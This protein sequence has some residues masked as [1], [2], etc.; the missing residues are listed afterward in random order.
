[1]KILRLLSLLLTAILISLN[2]YADEVS[3]GNNPVDV[4]NQTTIIGSSVQSKDNND[5]DNKVS[6]IK[7]LK[8]GKIDMNN[9]DPRVPRFVRFCMKVYKW[10]DRTFNSTDTNYVVGTGRR[11]KARM[12]SDN[13]VETYNLDLEKKLPVELNSDIYSN[14]GAYLQYMALSLG[15][16]F[17]LSNIIG[18]RRS[19]HRKTELGFNCARFNVE[20]HYWENNGG[21][22]IRRFGEYQN[23]EKVDIPFNGLKLRTFGVVGYYFFNNR[24]YSM[25]AAYNFSKIQKRSAGSWV[26]GF[27]YNNLNINFDFSTLPEELMHYYTFTETKYQFHYRNYCLEGGYGYNLVLNKHFLFN[28]Q[29][30]PGV[31]FARSYS[32]N[33]DGSATTAAFFIKGMGSLTYNNGDLFACLISRVEGNWY[34]S[35][36]YSVLNNMF[37]FQLSAGVRF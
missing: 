9:P 21:T 5:K 13:W 15:Y 16:S 29:A 33:V 37:N 27:S 14:A 7:L 18:A 30:I 36:K 19:N 26:V 6:W 2:T 12:V 22:H 32:D 28:I 24:K 11:W 8:Q 4:E 31:G 20:A 23:G 25:G 17:E 34:N 3:V 1:M 35:R 10:G